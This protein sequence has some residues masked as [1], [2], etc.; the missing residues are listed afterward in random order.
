MREKLETKW[1]HS[2]GKHKR[3]SRKTAGGCINSPVP[4]RVKHANV[5]AEYIEDIKLPYSWPGFL[6]NHNGGRGV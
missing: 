6:S 4:A 1:W 5:D 3:Y 2:T